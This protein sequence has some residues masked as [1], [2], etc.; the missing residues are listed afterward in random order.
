MLKYLFSYKRRIPLFFILTLISGMF[1]VFP[2]HNFQLKFSQGDNGNDMYCFWRAFEGGRVYQDFWWDYGP[3]MPYYYGFFFRVFG[4]S[5]HGA[6]IGYTLIYFLAGIFFFLAL[7][8]VIPSYMSYVATVWFWVFDPRFDHTY[9]HAGGILF[10]VI[11]MYFFFRY[12]KEQKGRDLYMALLCIFLLSLVKLNFGIVALASFVLSLK[13]VDAL[14]KKSPCANKKQIYFAAIVMVPL[15]ILLVYGSLLQGIPPEHARECLPF[16]RADRLYHASPWQS[17]HLLGKTQLDRMRRIFPLLILNILWGCSSGYLLYCLYKGRLDYSMKLK[18]LGSL[19]VLLIFFVFHFHEF[20]LSGVVYR[21]SW[22][23][24]FQVM[25][26][27]I[28][29]SLAMERMSKTA[30]IILC[31]VILWMS[32]FTHAARYKFVSL[33]KNP[34]RYIGHERGK[35]YVANS[36]EWM[37]TVRLASGYLTDHLKDDETFLALIFEP[38]YYFLT[39]KESPHRRIVF[40]E[41]MGISREEENEIISTLEGKGIRYILL[42]NKC[43]YD[44]QGIGIFGETHCHLL[45]SYLMRNYQPVAVF[46]DWNK[47]PLW[48]ER[49]AVM[50]LKKKEK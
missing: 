46:G 35:V 29:I 16:L 44:E 34:S 22:V 11:T 9:N 49:H 19:S 27:F 8:Q 38:L 45:S 32:F 20:F 39:A 4:V 47:A 17:L 18:L 12:L 28:I 14:D 24:P 25:A 42:S 26:M 43:N 13:T 41:F 21:M 31:C 5:I 40:Y 30:K 33:L 15:L 6:L 36:N 37:D 1:L 7:R 23:I 50:I 10:I 3:L 48:A 2:F